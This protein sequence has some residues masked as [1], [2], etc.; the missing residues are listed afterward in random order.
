MK[1]EKPYT[2]PALLLC[3]SILSANSIG[4]ELSASSGESLLHL[5]DYEDGSLQSLTTSGNAPTPTREVSRSGNWAMKSFLDRQESPT[6]YRTEA[7]VPGSM[8]IG[9]EYW[10]GVS[11]YLPEDHKPSDTWEILLQAFRSPDDWAT[12]NQSNPVFSLAILNDSWNAAIRYNPVPNGGQD[13]GQKTALSKSL[14]KYK[15]GV[16]TDFVFNWKWAYDHGQ[17]GFTKIWLNGELV[18]DYNGPNAYHDKA[19]PYLKYGIYKGWRDR[20]DPPDSVSTRVIYHDEIRL[21]GEN[22]SYAAVAPRGFARRPAPPG[23][24]RSASPD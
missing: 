3:L 11:I 6:S 9:K 1:Q 4:E 17:G 15:T 22:G 21:A 5:V 20:Y 8:E 14:G 2:R 23:A 10:V 19:G 13:D 16:W 18:V 24:F 7:R 12:Y